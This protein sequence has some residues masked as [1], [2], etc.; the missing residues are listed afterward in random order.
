MCVYFN[1]IFKNMIIVILCE[2][3]I[4]AGVLYWKFVMY[5]IVMYMFVCLSTCGC[6]CV[7]ACLCCLYVSVYVFLCVC[8]CLCVCGCVCACVRLCHSRYNQHGLEIVQ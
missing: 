3:L 6:V 1:R 8:L 5:C 4:S 2:L 7:C